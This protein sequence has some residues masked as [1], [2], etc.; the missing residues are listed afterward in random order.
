MD[1]FYRRFAVGAGQDFQQFRID[2]HRFLR[3]PKDYNILK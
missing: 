3:D 1:E 2:G